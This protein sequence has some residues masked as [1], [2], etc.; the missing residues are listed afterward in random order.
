MLEGLVELDPLCRWDAGEAA[1]GYLRAAG[2][3]LRRT[4]PVRTTRT[5]DLGRKYACPEPRTPG[6]RAQ[7]LVQ[8][9]L[10]A[11]GSRV[12]RPRARRRQ[13]AGRRPHVEHRP[14]ALERDRRRRS[15]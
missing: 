6:G 3:R 1:A 15:R 10:L 11:R 8:R 14:P 13:T 5:R 12:L 9:R 2:V 7:T 4:A